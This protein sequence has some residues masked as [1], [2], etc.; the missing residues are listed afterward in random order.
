MKLQLVS[1]SNS[2]NVDKSGMQEKRGSL[3]IAY[4][5]RNEKTKKISPFLVLNSL[6]MN[7]NYVLWSYCKTP[8]T[9]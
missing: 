8:K 6:I 2:Y 1:L 5:Y 9:G 4:L 3:K 7:I